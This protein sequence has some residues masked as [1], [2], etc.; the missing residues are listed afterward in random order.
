M[1]EC[2][3]AT[4]T[5]DANRLGDRVGWAHGLTVKLPKEVADAARDG[6]TSAEALSQAQREAAE[7]LRLR[8]AFLSA[9]PASAKLPFN[10]R[11]IWGPARRGIA[12][13]MGRA[14]RLT[15]NKWANFPG[16][17][18]DLSADVAADLVGSDTIRLPQ[19]TPVMLTHDID[20]PEGLLNLVNVFLPIEEQ[21]GVRSASYI[22]PH[23]WP[24]DSTIIEDIVARGHEIGV[25]G[26]DHSNTTPFL[27][28]QER[29]QRIAAGF[30]FAERFQGSGYRAPSLVRTR[31]LIDD[32]ALY[33]E[34]DSS[35]PTSGGPF[36]TANNGCAT[37]RPWRIVR[38]SGSEM[39]EIPLSLPRDGSLRFQGYAPDAIVKI[40]LDGANLLAR[41]HGGVNLLTHC[42]SSFSGNAPMLRAY[43]KFI[44]AI[45]DN[46]RFEFVLPR[47]LVELLKRHT[48]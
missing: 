19:P 45:A 40:W 41:A 23:A 46:P 11:K 16:W 4:V 34:Y 21:F 26:Y 37:A 18:I 7:N 24:I 32:L 12:G 47:T 15:Q 33:Y 28:E 6:A 39:W 3:L 25:H 31:E 5:I 22:V 43:H 48:P 20:S 36:P 27:A 1:V 38:R 10:Y 42:E 17:P 35:I 14:Q 8:R 44:A 30:A 29:R 13:V 9:P 2:A